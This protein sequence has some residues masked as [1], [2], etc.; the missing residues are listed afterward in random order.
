MV[1][2]D[3]DAPRILVLGCGNSKLS[4]LIY[5]NGHADITNVDFSSVVIKDMKDRYR[6]YEGMLCTCAPPLPWP[7]SCP[8]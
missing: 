5:N 3:Y 8:A 2:T 4:E 6:T 7:R 1:F